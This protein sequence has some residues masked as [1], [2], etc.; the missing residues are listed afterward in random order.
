MKRFG[1]ICIVLGIAAPILYSFMWFVLGLFGIHD[2]GWTFYTPYSSMYEEPTRVVAMP[3]MLFVFA[4]NWLAYY[5]WTRLESGRG[6][7]LTMVLIGLLVPLALELIPFVLTLVSKP[8]GEP[9]QRYHYYYSAPEPRPFNILELFGEPGWI[10]HVV[11]LVF[12]ML[13]LSIRTKISYSDSLPP[14]D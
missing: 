3:M 10:G 11:G 13:G 7:A 12:L 14:T 2:G 9:P 5:G 6:T 8:L 1:Q 4:G